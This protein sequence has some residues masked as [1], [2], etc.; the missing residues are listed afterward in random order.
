MEYY[1]CRYSNLSIIQQGRLILAISLLIFAVDSHQNWWEVTPFMNF[2]HPEKW[3]P[4]T[5]YYKEDHKIRYD[6]IEY[7]FKNYIKVILNF[8]RICS[9]FFNNEV[10]Q[11][12]INMLLQTIKTVGRIIEGRPTVQ[13]YIEVY[14]GDKIWSKNRDESNYKIAYV[15]FLQT[16]LYKNFRSRKESIED[17]LRNGARCWW[18]EI[19]AWKGNNKGPQKM[20]RNT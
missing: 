11:W 12:Q 5:L 3:Q 1:K 18:A 13:Y 7:E 2:P 16:Q 8:R 6:L 14:R 17:L 20:E 4:Y 15:N 19:A 10:D 9:I